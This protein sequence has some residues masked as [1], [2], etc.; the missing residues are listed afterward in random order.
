MKNLKYDNENQFI[1]DFSNQLR[2]T[3]ENFTIESNKRIGQKELDIFLQNPI[4]GSTYAIE[5][6]GSPKDTSLPPEIIPWLQTFKNT[7][8]HT[9]NINIDH[10]KPNTHFIVLTMSQINENIKGLF[11]KSGL[12][13]FEYSKHKE[14]L[15]NDFASFINELEERN[16]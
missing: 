15:T 12:E 10:I 9:N 7:I 14:N 5:V 3:M 6:K 1:A 13:I 16:L 8:Q 2:T 11:K 4:T